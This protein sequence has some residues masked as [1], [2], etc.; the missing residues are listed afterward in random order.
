LDQITSDAES[1][2]RDS[3]TSESLSKRGLESAED[4]EANSKRQLITK[5]GVV[6]Q[7]QD[8][9]LMI[10]TVEGMFNKNADDIG[11]NFIENDKVSLGFLFQ[12]SDD[13][14][15][16]RFCWPVKL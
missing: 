4:H 9:I 14:L 15:S 5:P 2:V 13:I 11:Y 3:F 6:E 16:C 12:F 1:Q 8:G 7:S 10:K